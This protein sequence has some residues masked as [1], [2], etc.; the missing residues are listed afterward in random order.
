MCSILHLRVILLPL[1]SGSFRLGGVKLTEIAFIV[2]E[3]L[4][5]LMDDVGCDSIKECSVM[6]D[7]KQG[8]LPCL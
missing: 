7:N 4:G 5:M 3:S 8:A 6:R 1:I 2:I